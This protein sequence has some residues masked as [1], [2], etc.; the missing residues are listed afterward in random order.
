M[1]AWMDVDLVEYVERKE[2]QNGLEKTEL[3]AHIYIYVYSTASYNE[4]KGEENKL[5]PGL[6]STI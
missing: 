4:G 5:C 1:N 3:L 2:K 6:D